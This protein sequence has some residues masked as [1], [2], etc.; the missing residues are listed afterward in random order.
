MRIIIY[1]QEPLPVFLNPVVTI[2]AFDGLHSA[3][4]QIIT[5]LINSA[6]SISG[7]SI[8]ITFDP[9]PR[10]ILDP[11][12][13]SL[14]LL[15][16]LE[17][18]IKILEETDLDY[19]VIVPFDYSFSMMMPE[20][21]IEN[22]LIEQF[23]P[24]KIIAGY[25]HRF[26]RD[27]R[28]DISLIKYYATQR[29]FDFEEIEAQT[30]AQST[31]SSSRIR[32]YLSS[33]QILKANTLLGY[34]YMLSG[35]VVPGNRIG[36][37][38]GFPTANIEITNSFK[39]IPPDGIYAACCKVSGKL[40]DGMLY[41]GNS[42]VVTDGKKRT[43][44]IN[45]FDFVEEIYGRQITVYVLDHIRE[46][47]N[48]ES[49]EALKNQIKE[50][51]LLIKSAIT[52]Y[53]IHF[54]PILKP[55]VAIA[56]LNFNGR[57]FLEKY[58]PSIVQ[59]TPSQFSIYIIDNNSTDS[60]CQYLE[61]H[62]PEIHLI[63]LR[64]NYGFAGGYNKGLAQIVADYFVLINSDLIIKTDWITGI[65]NKMQEEPDILVVQ[66]KIIDLN[67]QT[68]FEY[69]GASGGYIDILGYPFCRGR[70][71]DMIETDH[72]QYD[73]QEEIFWASGAAMI[74]N[75]YA[76][77]AIGGFDNDY[78]AHQ[79][80]IDLC[81]RLKRIGGKIIC[82]PESVVY[83]LGGG[84]LDYNNPRKTYLN[85]R[86]NLF[87]IFKNCTWRSLIFILPIRLVL[88]ALIIISYLAK[89]QF[90]VA[91]KIIQAY[92][93][94]IINTVYLIHK[95]NHTDSLIQKLKYY[96]YNKTGILK[97]SIFLQYYFSG[98]KLFSKIP[99][100]YFMKK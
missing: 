85:F 30:L 59:H 79:E 28:G 75:A 87:T 61:H 13:K 11:S 14:K 25:D 76:F 45:I 42:P 4:M 88:D 39:L 96:T 40:Y 35:K 83:H 10:S 37:E 92:V 5:R 34:P 1:G 93:V 2:G 24:K 56:I 98:N 72:G 36:R 63:K 12:D 43:I 19:F 67:D 33:H 29:N 15:T 44:E 23:Y 52:R 100:S 7:N 9:H 73:N 48:F 97:A 82:M 58:L 53:K 54:R 84:T 70:I 77:K 81:W 32:E 91:Y 3:H 86:N 65:I 20:E 90:N 17:E 21:Y 78:F 38:I 66:P 74:I 49:K 47:K 62:Y 94:S 50:D 89:G 57:H 99:P 26:G 51:E 27:G 22:F 60:S 46:D 16:T 55:K 18:R 71:I 6:K 68:K 69:A 8:L 41:I 64:R 80:E 31:I 95:K